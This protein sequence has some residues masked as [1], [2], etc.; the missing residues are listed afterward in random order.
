[1]G[2]QKAD[3]CIFCKDDLEEWDYDDFSENGNRA[4]EDFDKDL[5]ICKDCLGKLKLLLK[6][7]GGNK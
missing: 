7:K 4:S 1:M 3:E 2:E 6:L 5:D